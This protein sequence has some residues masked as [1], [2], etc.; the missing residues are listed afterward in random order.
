MRLSD[1]KALTFD[2]YGTLIDWES[3]MV[4][5]LKSLTD[6]LDQELSRDHILQA[7]ARHESSQQAQ[8]PGM[9]YRHLLAVVYK[10]LAEEWGTS[11]TW[12][13]CLA[14]GQ[15][16]KDWPAFEDSVAALHY[17]KRH[18]IGCLSSRA[19]VSSRSRQSSSANAL[20]RL[21]A[22]RLLAWFG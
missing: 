21:F 1:F 5:A 14:Y 9:R 8:T 6:R 7:H 4:S 19:M 2:C 17:L 11:V 20:N 12:D 13:D 3:G 10:R 22:H 18:Y 16:V 15:S